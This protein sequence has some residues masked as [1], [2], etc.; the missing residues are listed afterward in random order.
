MK[1]RLEDLLSD[2]DKMLAEHE[3]KER[4]HNSSA[5]LSN[6]VDHDTAVRFNAIPA[7]PNLVFWKRYPR[8]AGLLTCL[9]IVLIA[10]RI[11]MVVTMPRAIGHY[12]VV[13]GIVKNSSFSS[14]RQS[15]GGH[16]ATSRVLLPNGN[17]IAIRVDSGT[18]LPEGTMVPIRLYDTGAV[19][20]DHKE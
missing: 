9:F 15:Y 11:Y 7:E 4:V 18:M 6:E 2:A 20:L 19:R 17:V 3:E 8:V 16:V 1:E 12:N 14:T 5:A 10:V 13:T